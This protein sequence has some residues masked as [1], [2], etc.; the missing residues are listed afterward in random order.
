MD[1]AH[2]AVNHAETYVDGEVST[3]G[4]EYFWSLFKRR[5]KGTYVSVDPFHLPCYLD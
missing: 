1:Y 5:V 4:I 3:N 2:L